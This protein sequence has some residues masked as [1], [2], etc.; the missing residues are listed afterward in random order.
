M[1]NSL[2]VLQWLAMF[3]LAAGA[4]SSGCATA[5][6]LRDFTTDGCSL[7]P[8]GTLRSRD[9]W[10]GCCYVHDVRYWEGGTE[11]A[12][13]RADGALRACVLEAT[14]DAVLANLMYDGVRVG[15]HPAFPVPYRWGFGWPYER[16]YGPLTAEEQDEVARKK[17]QLCAR[18]E[19]SLTPGGAIRVARDRE[20]SVEVAAQICPDLAVPNRN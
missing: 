16:G 14:G 7:F 18:L 20:I 19:A 12:R 3:L 5:S 15:G 10:F 6:G 11:D 9:R 8:D 17:Q 2:L 4:A 13:K 1:R